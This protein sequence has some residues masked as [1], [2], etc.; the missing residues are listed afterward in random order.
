M[1]RQNRGLKGLSR[2]SIFRS[3][4]ETAT[5]EHFVFSRAVPSG[6]AGDWK[7]NDNPLQNAK[8]NL[9]GE[10]NYLWLQATERG[11]FVGVTA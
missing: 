9:A 3:L 7:D 2:N 6:V 10:G 1:F 4:P 11:H 8:K 5:W